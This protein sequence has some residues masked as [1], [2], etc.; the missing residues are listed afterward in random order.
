M[1]K[2]GLAKAYTVL[3]IEDNIDNVHLVEKILGR[4][5]SIEMLAASDAD[6]GIELAVTRQPDLILLDIN[7]GGKDG[8]A[9]LADLQKNERTRCIPVVGLSANAMPDDIEKALAGGF[10]EYITKPI[11]ISQFLAKIDELLELHS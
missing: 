1:S 8:Y 9:V 5:E 3:Y 2:D 11:D 4:R 7:L 10:K 6:S